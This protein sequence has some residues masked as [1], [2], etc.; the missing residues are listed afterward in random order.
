VLQLV[1]PGTRIGED[2]LLLMCDLIDLC[3]HRIARRA[4]QIASG[5]SFRAST[6]GTD[7]L[8]HQVL[9]HR[10]LPHR[11]EFLIAIDD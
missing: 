6:L 10:T 9:A 2:A 8:G 1:H 4:D 7:R 5:S 3:L 11:E